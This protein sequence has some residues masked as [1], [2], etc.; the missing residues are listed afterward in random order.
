M[1]SIAC[2]AEPSFAL[3]SPAS[4]SKGTTMKYAIIALFGI[5]LQA[6]TTGMLCWVPDKTDISKRV[7]KDLPPTVKA[8]VGTWLATQTDPPVAPAT[9]PTPQYSGIGDLLLTHSFRVI[10]RIIDL[11]PPPSIATPK[12]DAATA[13]ALAES[14]KVGLLDRTKAAEPK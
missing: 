9:E 11:A 6:Q 8:S 14:R 10:D 1:S 3:R 5:A 12:A 13:L 2:L 4:N 7:C